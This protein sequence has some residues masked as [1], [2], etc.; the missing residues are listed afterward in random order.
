MLVPNV[1][2]PGRII[3]HR[4]ASRRAPE[5]TLAAFRSAADQGAI[6]V[7]FDVSLLGD[8]TPVLHHDATLD[9]CTSSTGPLSAVSVAELPGLDAGTWFSDLFRGEPLPTL[10]N[11]L[12]LLEELGLYANLEIKPHELDPEHVAKTVSHLLSE[13]EWTRKRIIVSSFSVPALETVRIH[14]PDQPIAVLWKSPPTGWQE[15]VHQ[16]KAAAIHVNY[17]ALH[18]DLLLETRTAA[19]D[20]RVYTINRPEVVEI[21]RDQG[22]TGVITDHPPLFLEDP[23]WR[24]WSQVHS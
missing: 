19:V 15:T 18:S 21:F 13:K 8:G 5:N 16:L 6:W 23:A 12:D 17:R 2:D 24:E 9:R 14:L 7:E 11:G 22:L 1:T 4:G 10:T 20:L 3:A